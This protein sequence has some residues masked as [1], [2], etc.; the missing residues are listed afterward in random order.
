VFE[1]SA[2]AETRVTEGSLA[3]RGTLSIAG[4]CAAVPLG[5]SGA[6]IRIGSIPGDSTV[7][8]DP[9]LFTAGLGEIRLNDGGNRVEGTLRTG[10][11]A[12]PAAGVR[13]EGGALYAAP[14]ASIDASDSNPFVIDCDPNEGGVLGVSAMT[15]SGPLVWRRGSFLL[16]PSGSAF[17]N[18][19]I[20]T[21]RV[22][23]GFA[24]QIGGA[25]PAAADTVQAGLPNELSGAIVNE[26]SI[27]I[28]A[29]AGAAWTHRNEGLLFNYGTI[30]LE[31]NNNIQV[32]SLVG[33]NAS[34]TNTGLLTKSGGSGSA[35][36]DVRLNNTGVVE[37][38][39]GRVAVRSTLQIDPDTRTVT[40]GTWRAVAGGASSF[41]SSRV[42]A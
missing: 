1:Q 7:M 23:G 40:G 19:G 38:Q 15:N 14:A 8:V 37:S 39:S 25:K 18:S 29:F 28:D 31:G 2:G 41:S 12:D 6:E 21:I 4:D 42:S 27:A 17:V 22:A 24:R 11:S 5:A 34:L 30:D 26:G 3:L 33:S 35:F 20:G 10:G 13:F 32:D 36:I 9:L 16:A